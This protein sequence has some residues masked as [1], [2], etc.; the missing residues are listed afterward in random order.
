MR[1]WI[2]SHHV[3]MFWIILIEKKRF[4]YHKRDRE[5][6]GRTITTNISGE[7]YCYDMQFDAEKIAI[8]I[9]HRYNFKYCDLM[10]ISCYQ[11]TNTHTLT[12]TGL[13]LFVN[14]NEQRIWKNEVFE[15]KSKLFYWNFVICYYF[16]QKS[17]W[18]FQFIINNST[19]TSSFDF[20]NHGNAI[21]R[22]E[23]E[24]QHIVHCVNINKNA[25]KNWL[26]I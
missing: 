26:Q 3:W 16:V 5:I 17:I 1:K 14:K 22:I 7:C 11:H 21:N 25:R 18:I 6:R 20:M 2:P 24:Y 19:I 15:V 23:M 12:N 13:L 9:N 8:K 10:W 4:S